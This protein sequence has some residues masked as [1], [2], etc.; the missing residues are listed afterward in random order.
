MAKHKKLNAIGQSRGERYVRL[1]WYMLQ[2]EAWRS[3]TPNAKALLLDVWA[4]HN[5]INNGE[6]SYAVRE[7]RKIGLGRHAATD[8]FDLL[9][10]R[11][12]LRVTRNSGFNVKRRDAHLWAVT[13]EKVGD[14]PPT[15]DF[16]RWRLPPSISQ[17]PCAGSIR[18]SPPGDLQ[19]PQTRLSNRERSNKRST[20]PSRRLQTP[21]TPRLQSP[22][23]DTS[24]LPGGGDRYSV[25][26]TS[27]NGD[28]TAFFDVIRAKAL[29]EGLSITTLAARCGISRPQLSNA[30]AGRT[31]LSPAAMALLRGYAE[32]IH[33]SVPA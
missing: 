4:R 14:R 12:F 2:S 19:S 3:L 10:E 28:G 24:N 18:Q 33:Q 31:Q 13:A 9:I 7:A 23:G 22:P 11:G 25:G 21:Q 6:I 30:L 1:Q 32:Q 27:A 29:A 16:M 15:K 20:V 26:A 17:T 5:G 8:A